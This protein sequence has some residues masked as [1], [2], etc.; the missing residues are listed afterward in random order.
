MQEP[1]KNWKRSRH[2]ALERARRYSVEPLEPLF[3]IYIAL[4]VY[5]LIGFLRFSFFDHPD[6]FS[7][8]EAF[9]LVTLAAAGGLVLILTGSVLTLS[10]TSRK[11]Q[12]LA[13]K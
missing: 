7:A 10:F 1:S 8:L 11:L 5:Y 9:Q 3:P 2:A 4:C 13:D 12:E 6:T